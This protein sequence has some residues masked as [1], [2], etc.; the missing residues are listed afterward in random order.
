[1]IENVVAYPSAQQAFGRYVKDTFAATHKLDPTKLRT[2]VVSND[3]EN[4]ANAYET[5]SVDF[6]LNARELYRIFMRTG[7]NM[8]TLRDAELDRLGIESAEPTALLKRIQWNMDRESEMCRM[9]FGGKC[10]NV[11]FAHNLGQARA[12][13]EDV[14][15]G[16]ASQQVIRVIA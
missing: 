2:I 16:R 6:S 3:N 8:N 14:R 12:L 5:G 9:D 7:G 11:A 10:L 15:A 1:M 13:L 4:G